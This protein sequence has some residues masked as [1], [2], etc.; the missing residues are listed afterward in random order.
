MT[1]TTHH[2]PQEHTGLRQRDIRPKQK[3]N[4]A[5]KAKTGDRPTAVLYLRVST[6]EQ[7][8]RGGEA[9]GFSIPAQRDACRRKA[10]SLGAV[11]VEE[12]ID[13]GESAKSANR[14]RLK[15]MLDFITEHRP[16]YVIVHK[17]DRLARN[18]AD[19][20]MI[21]LTITTAGCQLVSVSENIDTTP[22]GTLLHGIMSSIAEFYSRNLAAE[23]MK[24]T[25][26]KAETGGTPFKAPLGYLNT[27]QTID[28][29]EVRT[30]TLDPE[31]ADHIV[32]LFKTYATGDYSLEELARMANARGLTTRPTP[33]QPAKPLTYKSIALILH[34]PYYIGV[35]RYRG[36][37]Y[38]GQ[39]EALIPIDLFQKCQ[40]VI[41]GRAQSTERPSKHRHYLTGTVKCARC[42]YGLIYNVITKRN[43][44]TGTVKQYDY[45][46]CQNRLNGGKKSLAGLSCDLPYLPVEEV[47]AVVDQVWQGEQLPP[48]VLAE[49]TA[50]LEAELDTTQADLRSEVASLDQRIGQIKA[51]RVKWAE[52]AMSQTVPADIA[53]EKQATLAAALRELEARRSMIDNSVRQ[54]R[55]AIA[56]V[57]DLLG[58]CG[59]L[60]GENDPDLRRTMNQSYFARIDMDDRG[61][62]TTVEQVERVEVF[63]LLREAVQSGV[64]SGANSPATR[65]GRAGVA[66][67]GSGVAGTTRTATATAQAGR[68]A[69]GGAGGGSAS[70]ADS[71]AATAGV[72]SAT[73]VADGQAQPDMCNAA[74][75]ASSQVRTPDTRLGAGSAEDQPLTQHLRRSGTQKR[76]VSLR[77]VVA[78]STAYVASSNF[79]TLVEV[80]G[81][82]PASDDG[83]PGL[84][85]V[86]SAHVFLGPRTR[87]D[88][89]RTG[90]VT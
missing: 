12:F 87:A 14:P 15:Q 17:I 49:L 29:R 43:K 64:A 7:A 81:I 59:D 69:V 73:Q 25:V 42:G 10:E 68:V 6:R 33:T 38:D 27:R 1:L 8:Q 78:F 13:A 50:N 4:A 55:V 72:G 36:Q 61:G 66:Q 20:V 3:P 76:P 80:A 58:Q 83:E 85:R 86:Q 57:T 90:S 32:W 19:D 40:E 28:G 53:G 67:D 70:G 51:E 63:G 60:Y 35:V 88:K 46:T 26:Q 82:E 23:V 47:E 44:R 89:V 41:T 39:H 54:G 56:E 71:L 22:S 77:D 75:A 65:P 18:R 31:R 34:N 45:F 11:V 74:E 16:T 52:A 5:T 24:G 37:E 48:K 84:L 9:E 2:Q 30:I 62:R 79:R 21:S